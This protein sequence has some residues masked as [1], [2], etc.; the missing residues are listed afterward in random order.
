MALHA[1]EGD[2][3][4]RQTER[5][6]GASKPDGERKIANRGHASAVGALA[7]GLKLVRGFPGRWELLCV[8][9]E[10]WDRGRRN[11]RAGGGRAVGACR[12]MPWTCWSGLRIRVRWGRGCCCSR[13]G[14][15]CWSGS[16][17]SRRCA[18]APP[19]SS[20]S[21][22]RPS[23]AGGSWIWPIPV[24]HGLGVHR[25]ALFT[26]LRGAAE[27]EGARVLAGAEVVQRR[28][29]ARAGRRRRRHVRA[30][31][32]DRRS[33]RGALDDAPLP[34]VPR[35][36]PRTPLG[37]AVGRLP[38]PVER[39]P[40]RAS[41]STS[42]ARG[43]WRASCPPAATRSRCSGRSGW[44]GSRPRGRPGWRRSA[45]ICFARARGR[46]A[47]GGAA[48]VRSAAARR[49]PPGQPPALA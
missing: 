3:H 22:A 17:C 20:G 41:T 21:S 19:G 2:D 49:L 6:E 34:A 13:P 29:V 28:R 5:A 14:W 38:G 25:G 7:L 10:S 12:A 26:A 31:R 16:A 18:R 33:R 27:R 48:F 1:G 37:R 36:H 32:P 43:G 8:R 30:V 15:R 44:T 35:A 11:G 47:D 23:K 46:A 45:T 39:L 24:E 9:D 42:T 40:R 4:Q